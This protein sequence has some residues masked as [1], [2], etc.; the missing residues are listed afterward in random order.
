LLKIPSFDLATPGP[1]VTEAMCAAVEAV[2]AMAE[3]VLL[4]FM[5]GRRA[6][7]PAI[8]APPSADTKGSS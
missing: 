8:Y 5:R 6:P 3:Q 4:A 1:D 2:V 7:Q